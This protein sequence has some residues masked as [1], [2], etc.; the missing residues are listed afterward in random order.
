MA[1]L[2]R[3]GIARIVEGYHILP[4]HPAFHPQAERAVF[5]FPPTAGT[6]LGYR[7]RK[8]KRSLRG[9]GAWGA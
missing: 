8:H 5:A 6:H 2:R 9:G 1:S 3:A 4:A 7:P